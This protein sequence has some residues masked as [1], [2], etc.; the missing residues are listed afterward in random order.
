MRFALVCTDEEACCDKCNLEIIYSFFARRFGVRVLR[1]KDINSFFELA[2]D[3]VEFSG[4]LLKMKE[5]SSEAFVFQS[6]MERRFPNVKCFVIADQKKSGPGYVQAGADRVYVGPLH[7]REQKER[8]HDMLVRVFEGAPPEAPGGPSS[9]VLPGKSERI[10]LDTDSLSLVV[11]SKEVKLTRK[12]FQ[13]IEYLH[14]AKKAVSTEELLERLWDPY[15]APEIVRQYI[16]K[17][18]H[19]IAMHTG[20]ERMIVY[21]RGAGY[22][23]TGTGGAIAD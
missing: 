6:I 16:Y 9:S 4:V 1:L 17:L 18:R 3:K 10:K 19:K 11:A 23:L 14:T 21:R 5:L 2:E 8:L 20:E 12:E 15:T 13:L 7:S 22:Q